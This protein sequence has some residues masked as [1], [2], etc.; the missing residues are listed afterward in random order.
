MVCER[1]CSDKTDVNLTYC[2][3][4]RRFWLVLFLSHPVSD[5]RSRA[6]L[7]SVW[8]GWVELTRTMETDPEARWHVPKAIEQ[9][10][11]R[12]TGY[13]RVSQLQHN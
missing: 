13:S 9:S 1:G 4:H 8:L 7:A 5:S 2:Q 12:V 10:D 6:E 3:S 11:V